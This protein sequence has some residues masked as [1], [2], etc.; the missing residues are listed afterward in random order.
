M[1]TENDQYTQ[2]TPIE[3][4][5]LNLENIAAGN[6]V[7]IYVPKKTIEQRLEEIEKTLA[8]FSQAIED[9]KSDCA[10]YREA[11]EHTDDSVSNIRQKV[12]TLV[13]KD[14]ITT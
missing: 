9:L 14:P 8:T 13:S 2:N 7:L 12:S 6:R 5:I 11:F 1:S 4:R 10:D 3:E